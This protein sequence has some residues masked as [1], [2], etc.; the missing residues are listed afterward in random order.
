MFLSQKKTWPAVF[1]FTQ[2]T[3]SPQLMWLPTRSY[4]GLQLSLE[5]WFKL[6][7]VEI[8]SYADHFLFMLEV[9]KGEC[10]TEFKWG[11]LYLHWKLGGGN[12]VSSLNHMEVELCADSQNVRFKLYWMF[13]LASAV[14][15]ITRVLIRL[16]ILHFYKLWIREFAFSFARKME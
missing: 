13:S 10:L 4:A 14:T 6:E 16:V 15:R 11:L 1:D 12:V 7:L 8:G 3:Q 5:V 9:K 2:L